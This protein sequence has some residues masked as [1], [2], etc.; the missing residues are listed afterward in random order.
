MHNSFHVITP[1][2]SIETLPHLKSVPALKSPEMYRIKVKNKAKG[3][4]DVV[5]SL[6]ATCVGSS[7]SS[8]KENVPVDEWLKNKSSLI[9]VNLFELIEPDEEEG[10]DNPEKSTDA[11]GEDQ[12]SGIGFFFKD[13]QKAEDE[14]AKKRAAFLLKQRKAE[15]ACLRKQ[16]LE[17]KVELKRDEARRKAEEDRIRKDEEKA[18][19]ELIKQEYL[20]RKQQQI[21][22][23]QGLGRPKPKPKK[24]HPSPDLVC[25][26]HL[27]QLQR[28]KVSTLA[29]HHHTVDSVEVLSLRS[30]HQ[31]RMAEHSISGGIFRS[32][33]L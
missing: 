13:D 11:I 14:L 22:E 19:R 33:T 23:E 30:R 26:W 2:Q 4:K 18:R 5:N 20:Q 1:T 31:S 32:K 17:A 12:K 16:Q 24:S 8:G 28:Q 7:E 21:L 15:E 10:T 6:R 27:E 9:E 29:E 25:H 3:T